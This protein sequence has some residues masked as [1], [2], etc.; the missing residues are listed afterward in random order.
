MKSPK[1]ILEEIQV[2]PNEEI[3][4]DIDAIDAIIDEYANDPDEEFPGREAGYEGE[5]TW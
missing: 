4:I 3:D 2:D 1:T 5:Y